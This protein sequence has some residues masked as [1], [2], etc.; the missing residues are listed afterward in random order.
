[1]SFRTEADDID[2]LL[3]AASEVGRRLDQSLRPAVPAP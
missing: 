1:M 2:R 3:D